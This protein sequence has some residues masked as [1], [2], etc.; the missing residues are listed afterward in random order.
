MKFNMKIAA[1]VTIFTSSM[2]VIITGILLYKGH[3]HI[4]MLQYDGFG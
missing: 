2:L 4:M 1:I 3:Q